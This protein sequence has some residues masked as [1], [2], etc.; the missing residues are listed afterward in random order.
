MYKFYPE[1]CP[2]CGDE[3]KMTWIPSSGM[4]I[5]P[6]GMKYTCGTCGYTEVKNEEDN[7]QSA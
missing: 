2:K 3:M 1:K 4:D 5:K 7:K 6:T